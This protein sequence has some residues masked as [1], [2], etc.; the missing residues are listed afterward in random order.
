MVRV[1]KPNGNLFIWCNDSN[2]RYT[3]N[4]LSDRHKRKLIN[5][6][7]WY[8]PNAQPNVT[9]RTLQHSH[10]YVLWYVNGKSHWHFDYEMSKQIG[11]GKQLPDVWSLPY[12]HHTKRLHKNEKPVE[13][14]ERLLLFGTRPGDLV[15]DPFAGSGSTGE[16]CIDN[17]RRFVLIEKDPDAVRMAMGRLHNLHEIPN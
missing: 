12:I 17:N 13:L 2:R 11:G 9:K 6:I 10:E 16:A 4:E 14:L 7:V 8:K 3:E 1:V 5:S 15:L